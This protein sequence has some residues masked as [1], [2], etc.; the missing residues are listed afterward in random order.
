MKFSATVFLIVLLFPCCLLLAEEGQQIP[1][2]QWKAIIAYFPGTPME[3]TE[4][5]NWFLDD[6]QTHFDDDVNFFLVQYFAGDDLAVPVLSP[7][8]ELIAIVDISEHAGDLA[9]YIFAMK[10]AEPLWC[11]YEQSYVV[12]EQA[13]EYFYPECE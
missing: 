2:V 5:W 1:E 9:G 7:E 10:D 8:D 11:D 12:I 6:I 3:V 13:E 4:D